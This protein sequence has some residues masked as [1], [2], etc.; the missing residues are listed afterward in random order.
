MKVL[1]L[2]D[3][4]SCG[5]VALKRAGISIDKYYASEIKPFAIKCSSENNPDIIHIGDITK[6]HF[7]RGTLYTKD[8]RYN[9]GEIDLVIGGSPCQNFSVAR[10]SN[11]KT[12]DGLKG[13]QSSLFYEYAR[14]LQEIQPRYFLLENV[15]IT[16]PD[17]LAEINGLL[18][19]EPIRINSN[20][21]SFQNRDRFYWTNIPNV[22]IPNDKGVDFQNYKDTD[23]NYCDKFIV[24]RT[25]SREIMWGNGVNG[26]CKNITYCNKVNCLTLKQDRWA[27]S[28]LIAYKDFCRY[29][30][31]RELEL[32]QTLPIGY[33]KM[34]TRTQ[35]EN[36]LGDCWTVDVIAHIFKGLK[37]IKEVSQCANP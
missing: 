16:R 28:G 11:K 25:R 30:T 32:A 12:I 24:P 8:K 5:Y 15:R 37:N 13:E 33:T 29:L 9:L 19:V 4:I 22:T 20:L 27:N 35:A 36:V 6:I 23:E 18:Q 26:K 17:D 7:W 3:G 21:V 2:F 10:T 1:S 34:L 31:T 14:L